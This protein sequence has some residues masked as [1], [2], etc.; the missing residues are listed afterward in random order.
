MP[1]S[2]PRS[3]FLS[4]HR[5]IA[6]LAPPVCRRFV[7]RRNI[8]PSEWANRHAGSPEVYGKGRK[9]VHV[10]IEPAQIGRV[11]MPDYGVVSDAKA[12]L[13]LFVEVARERGAK[14]ALKDFGDWQFRCAER[15]RLLH[16]KTHYT[17]TP[18]KP[19]RVYEEMNQVFPRD[20]VYV[21]TIGLSQIAGAQF[22]HVYGPWRWTSACNWPTTTSMS[23]NL[24]CKAVAPTT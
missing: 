19:L 7:P 18:I 5:G 22:L 4:F 23:R 20:A 24:R 2:R 21:T 12:A 10:V 17:E 3:A 15:K 1:C 6:D 9:F 14:G 11:F 13:E 8:C 16:R